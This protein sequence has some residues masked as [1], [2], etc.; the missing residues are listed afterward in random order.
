MTQLFV[1]ESRLS[2]FLTKDTRSSLLW[3]P[4]RLYVGWEWLHAG[5][6]K[7]IDLDWVGRDA[8]APIVGFVQGALAL[9]GGPH[10]DV[11]WWYAAFLERFVQSHPA[12]WANLIA[13][14]ELLVGMGLIAGCLTGIAAFFGLFMNLNYLLGGTVSINPILFTLSIGLLLAWRV[15]GYWGADRFALPFLRERRRPK[16]ATAGATTDSCG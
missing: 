13:Y 8:G 5:W 1:R 7:V 6:E 15:A 3:L 12:F 9:T 11:T 14:G 4:V 16:A 2:R 10:P